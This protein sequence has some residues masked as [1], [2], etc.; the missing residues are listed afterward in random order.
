MSYLILLL[1]F[2]V[3]ANGQSEKTIPKPIK[4]ALISGDAKDLA[5]HFNKNIELL[6]LDNSDIYSKAQA[7]LIIK[8]FFKK[9][10]PSKLVI[11]NEGE[12][13]G[14]KY[15]IGKLKTSKG[16]FRIYIAYQTNKG[17][18]KINRL[19]LSKYN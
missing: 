10:E 15:S 18:I 7:E 4:K 9:N 8:D 13:E 5:T 2:F 12:S 16:D 11:E 17:N 19:N 1:C 14:V 3:Y 6:V